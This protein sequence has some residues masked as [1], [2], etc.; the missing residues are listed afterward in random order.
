MMSYL[1]EIG[2]IGLL[3][4]V[5][6]QDFKYRAVSWIVFPVLFVVSLM[7]ALGEINGFQLM[8]GAMVNLSLVA[9]IFIGL[10]IYFSVKEKALT[11]IINKY[12]GIADLLLLMVIAL[13]FSPVNFIMYYVISLVIITAG[14][15]VYLISKKNVNAEIPLAG[16]FS[17]V[18]IAC[19]V[20]AGIT[21][22]INFYNDEFVMELL[23][24]ILLTLN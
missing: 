7:L 20:Y 6:Y 1:I 17:I 16:A 8:Q 23:N 12:I 21:G 14:S 19:I 5:I 2:L 10:T 24:P 3:S 9:L 4:V 18:L 11:N 13:L 15:A 22:D